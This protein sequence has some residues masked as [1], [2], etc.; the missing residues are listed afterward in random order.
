VQRPERAGGKA[1]D[2]V[3]IDAVSIGEWFLFEGAADE[4]QH[5]AAERSVLLFRK[6]TD[7]FEQ[8]KREADRGRGWSFHA[9]MVGRRRMYPVLQVRFLT[10][11]RS[12]I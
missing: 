5:G 4:M 12:N 6:S 8:R 10:L 1:F 9:Y 3:G 11:T 2:L 7:A